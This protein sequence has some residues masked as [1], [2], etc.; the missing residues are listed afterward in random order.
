MPK[1]VPHAFCL[2]FHTR[3]MRSSKGI[4]MVTTV[5]GEY[6]NFTKFGGLDCDGI[7]KTCS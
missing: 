6:A 5:L 4:D 3:H 7:S 1:G 2:Q